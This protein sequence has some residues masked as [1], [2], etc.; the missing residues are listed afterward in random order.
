MF[1][2]TCVHVCACTHIAKSSKTSKKSKKKQTAHT[3]ALTPDH[4]HL[5]FGH[6]KA[7][8]ATLALLQHMLAH[9]THTP[10]TAAPSSHSEITEGACKSEVGVIRT[11]D[12]GAWIDLLLVGLGGGALPMFI[13]KCIPNV[14]FCCFVHI[15]HTHTRVACLLS[16]EA[17]YTV[18]IYGII[19]YTCVLCI[20]Q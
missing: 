5:N 4:T 1:S 11:G 14:S 2:S 15:T 7:I 9:S 10:S 6:H 16:L 19:T 17:G 12:L 13:S 3:A 18:K 20:T 8:I